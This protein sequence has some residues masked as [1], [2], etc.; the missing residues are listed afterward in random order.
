MTVSGGTQTT[1]LQEA[2]GRYRGDR[3]LVLVI[4]AVALLLDNML[5]TSVGEFRYIGL[6]RRWFQNL[7]RFLSVDPKLPKKSTSVVS[8]L[9]LVSFILVHCFSV[10]WSTLTASVL[11][12]RMNLPQLALILWRSSLCIPFW[13][14][15][16]I[17]YLFLS[18]KSWLNVVAGSSENAAIGLS[19]ERS[20][21]FCVIDAVQAS[22]SVWW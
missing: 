16:H 12:R 8:W 21:A 7:L 1:S 19:Y 15:E 18:S 10:P 2:I 22:R 9:K 4:V 17:I 3:K 6:H 14:F 5:L 20:G 13:E 11:H